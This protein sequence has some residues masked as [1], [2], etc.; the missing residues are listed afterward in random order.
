MIGFALA[1]T[2][3]A[4][5]A[6]VNVAPQDEMAAQAAQ[7]ARAVEAAVEQAPLRLCPVDVPDD[8]RAAMLEPF[9]PEADQQPARAL[10]DI[11]RKRY[12]ELAYE[13]ALE[14]LL[15]AET[16]ARH[17]DPAPTLWRLLT[18]IHI[19]LGVVNTARGTELAAV[20]SF[21][22][23]RALDPKLQLDPAYYPPAMRGL[24]ARAQPAGT[25]QIDVHDPAGTDVMIDGTRVGQAPL[26]REVGEGEHYVAMVAGG[27]E[28]RIERVPV[29][30]GKSSHVSIFLARRPVFEEVRALMADA[31]RH[32]RV[33]DEQAR[34]L[35]ALVGADLVL[36]VD[37]KRIHA[38]WEAPGRAPAAKLPDLTV[39]S[40]PPQLRPLLDALPHDSVIAL[41]P[42][43][44]LPAPKPW[45]GRWW[46][47]AIGGAL[48]AGT[49]VLA[50][51]AFSSKS[52]VYQFPP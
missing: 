15:D 19:M 27:R 13:R 24:F 28:P 12:G 33:D 23:A 34:R 16:Q 42:P 3:P 52:T 31:R 41:P 30:A 22:L 39:G 43:P 38:F 21:R 4:R 20:Q 7:S 17:A 29:V 11:A 48:A 14:A 9:D 51:E 26:L 50:I 44:P 1:L 35:A 10:L 18:D 40:E 49:T 46:V 2:S 25:G 47:W 37:G 36:A 32:G 6:V 8:V 5:T 45:Y